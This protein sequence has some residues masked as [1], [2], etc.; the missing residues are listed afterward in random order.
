VLWFA[1]LVR[2]LARLFPGYCFN[3]FD[4][5]CGNVSAT[6]VPLHAF[7]FGAR[8]PQTVFPARM[9]KIEL[10]PGRFSTTMLACG[11]SSR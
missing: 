10:Q 9:V 11:H 8:A 7:V 2:E 3:G 6:A 4:E 1:P 5:A